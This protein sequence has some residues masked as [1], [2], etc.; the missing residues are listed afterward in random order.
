MPLAS[1][2]P[3]PPLDPQPVDPDVVAAAESHPMRAV[4]HAAAAEVGAWSGG[5]PGQ[6]MRTFDGLA[7]E[8]H[9]RHGPGRLEALADA[10]DRGG[11]LP[12]DGP[13]LELGAGDGWGSATIAERAPSLAAVELSSGML[14]ASP[15]DGVPRLQ[16]DAA[17]LPLDDHS[18]ATAVLMN[19]LLFPTELDRVLRPGGALVWLSSRGPGTPIHLTAEQVAAA[20]PGR[21]GGVSSQHGTAT[22]AVLRRQG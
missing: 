17:A 18:V 8:W 21:W 2:T 3:R 16:A 4:T 5:L 15:A 9:T 6:V 10:L 14:A 7:G 13:W 1:L 20:L 19:M 11:P 22:W 12:A